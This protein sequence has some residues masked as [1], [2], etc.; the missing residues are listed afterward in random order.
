MYEVDTVNGKSKNNFVLQL[1][2][3]GEKSTH[4]VVERG[5]EILFVN[6]ILHLLVDQDE[7]RSILDELFDCYDKTFKKE[8]KSSKKKHK[9]KDLEKQEEDLQPEPIDVIVDIL[10]SFLTN[11]SPVLKN[12]SEQVFEI[13]SHKVTKRTLDILLNVIIACQRLLYFSLTFFY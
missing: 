9:K 6:V 10:V 8:K 7:A 13:F 12:L 3:Q 1:A 11:E 2:E 5:F 4:E